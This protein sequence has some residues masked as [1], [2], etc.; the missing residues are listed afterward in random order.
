M[1][2]FDRYAR[3]VD[4]LGD[5]IIPP[6]TWTDQLFGLLPPEEILHE[7][8][9][10]DHLL[11]AHS[12]RRN[13]IDTLCDYKRQFYD[14]SGWFGAE[15]SLQRFAHDE[16]LPA[17]WVRIGKRL[18]VGAPAHSCVVTARTALRVHEAR[19][20][21]NILDGVCIKTKSVTA[22]GRPVLL[23]PHR[24]YAE[25]GMNVTFMGEETVPNASL[26]ITIFS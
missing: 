25:G 24:L 2:R 8:Y 17:C 18:V 19:S 3:A 12:V 14:D 11:V 1:S 20:G 13:M 9:E 26:P 7:I 6:E 16:Y 15:G 23:G 4:L 10:Q 5:R 22:S 21:L